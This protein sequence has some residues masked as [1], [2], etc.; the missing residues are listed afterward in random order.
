MKKGR[1][2]INKKVAASNIIIIDLQQAIFV[3]I[4][5][6]LKSFAL[7]VLWENPGFGFGKS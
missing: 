5:L 4:D 3:L 7:S 2:A 6:K 1:K